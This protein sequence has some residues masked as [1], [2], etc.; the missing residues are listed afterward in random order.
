VTVRVTGLAAG[1]Q[2]GPRRPI[3]SCEDSIN[4]GRQLLMFPN[5]DNLPAQ[6]QEVLGRV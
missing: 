6:R 3:E 5:P 2:W 1:R 4:A